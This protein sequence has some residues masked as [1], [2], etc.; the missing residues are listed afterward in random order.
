MKKPDPAFLRFLRLFAANIPL[1]LSC[2]PASLP[3][4]ISTD[5]EHFHMN[6]MIDPQELARRFN[7]D[8][9]VWRSYENKRALR[10][11]VRPRSPLSEDVLDQLD[12]QAAERECREVRAVGFFP[13]R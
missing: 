11:L 10:R 7:E 1:Q 9:A 12:W 3:G 4:T 6:T 13:P 2:P 5:G 8:E